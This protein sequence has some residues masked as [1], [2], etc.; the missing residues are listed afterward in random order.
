LLGCAKAARDSRDIPALSADL[1]RVIGVS[2]EIGPEE[3]WRQLV[4][5]HR[6]VSSSQ[7]RSPVTN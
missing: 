2:G 6:I 4:P 3:N 7:A 5:H 1:G